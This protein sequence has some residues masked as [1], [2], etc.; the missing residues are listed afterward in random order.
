MHFALAVF[1]LFSQVDLTIQQIQGQSSSSPYVGQRVRTRG[2]VTGVY[3]SGVFIQDTAGGPWSGI[4]LHPAPNVARGDF[5]VITGVVIE[6]YNLTEIDSVSLDSVI[7]HGYTI[8]PETLRTGEVSNE[9][10]EGVLVTVGGAVCE[11]L[12][13]R[14]GE[15]WVN[16]GSG[17][18]MIDDLGYR[19]TPELGSCYN[20]TG[21][22]YYSYG[23][24]KIEPRDANDVVEVAC[25]IRFSSITFT[26][27]LPD[28]DQ[29]VTVIATISSS[30]TIL[31]DS[32]YYSTGNGWI[33]AGHDSVRNTTYFYTIPHQ[34]VGTTVRFYL[35]FWREDSTRVNSDTLMYMVPDFSQ[36]IPLSLVHV[37]DI[38]G[39]SI[40]EGRT[41]QF[42]GKLTTGGELG[43]TYFLQDT[44]GGIAIYNPGVTLN[45]G[46]SVVGTGTV[47]SYYGLAELKN[48]SFSL[49][50]PGEEIEPRTVTCSELSENGERYEGMLLRINGVTSTATYF[51]VDGTITISDS[52]GVF[53]LFIDRD[54]DLGGLPVPSGSFDIIGVLSQHD[55]TPPY[56]EGY[57]LVPRSHE[58]VIFTGDGSGEVYLIPPISFPGD[59]DTLN[60]LIK[61]IPGNIRLV[62]PQ[63]I[64]WSFDNA[65]L[66]LSIE[67][68]S[69]IFDENARFITIYTDTTEF[70][71]K[72]FNVV[73][74]DSS[75]D[76]E[77]MVKTSS[78]ATF[79]RIMVY[80]TLYVVTPIQEVQGIGYTSPYVGDTMRVGGWVIGPS[81]V[82]SPSGKTT[83]WIFDGT[84]GIECFSYSVT[85]PIKPGDFI[86]VRGMV[87][88]YNGL[89]Q[90]TFDTDELNRVYSELVEFLPAPDTLRE[91]EP[92]GEN[93]EGHL[94][95][96]TGTVANSPYRGGS[97]FNFT[98]LN[99]LTPIDIRVVDATGIDVSSISKGQV[100]RVKGI[101]SQYDPTEPYTSGYQVMPVDSGDIEILQGVV[102]ERVDLV[103]DKTVVVKEDGTTFRIEVKSPSTAENT[104]VVYDLEGRKIRTLV[105]RH[106]GPLVLTWDTLDEYGTQVKLGMYIIQLRSTNN[107]T[108]KVVNK[109]ILVTR[110]FK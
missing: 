49:I 77:F 24:Y 8:E 55:N 6:Y 14:W 65:E 23:N 2:V 19:A 94:V 50:Q 31:T 63:G 43:L 104:V 64:E 1:L 9:M 13:N 62:F 89:T 21:P 42:T 4:W 41:I 40:L 85:S 33:S 18:L 106:V 51:P 25:P 105:R 98:I 76:Y 102:Q 97:G 61:N 54:T 88:E 103:L 58:D 26:P 96:V 39:V 72:V 99:G 37:L 35:T 78:G 30:S 100:L 56:T 22:V 95:V 108:T 81:D 86:V 59:T 52:T 7:G 53:T 82:F 83:F 101:V 107:G 70:S 79:S 87:N 48:V 32:I 66:E 15:W 29:D 68:D 10:W 46:D 3:G 20:I 75:G 93:L 67:P 110:R 27:T 44:S 38:N 73:I 57:Q 74:P 11:S 16:D 92:I 71:L 12:P 80:P 47:E 90:I 91:S 60:F 69:V 28:P 34:P 5:I 17:L 84:G 45:R 36:P 109:L